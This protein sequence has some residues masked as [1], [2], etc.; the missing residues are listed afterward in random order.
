MVHRM[1]FSILAQR[2]AVAFP[3]RHHPRVRQLL[4]NTLRYLQSIKESQP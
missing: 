1:T 3:H 2:V 4:R